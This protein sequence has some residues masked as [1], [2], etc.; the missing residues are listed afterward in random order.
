MALS[1]PG[2]IHRT[3]A[4]LD[5]SAAGSL[6]QIATGKDSPILVII[7]LA[8]GNDGLNTIVPFADD[9]YH[10]ARPRLALGKNQVIPV[11]DH[12]GL[13]PALT[14]LHASLKNGDAAIVQGVGYPNPNRSHFRSME[15]WHTATDAD[16][17]SSSGWLGRYFDNCCEGEDPAPG[18]S[19]GSRAP[20]AFSSS[21]PRGI[22]L[23][24]PNAL[25]TEGGG[26]DM[27]MSAMDSEM[28]GDT[29]SMLDG[30]IEPEGDPADFIRRVALDAQIASDEILKA[31][32]K[33]HSSTEYPGS[34]LGRDL[35]FIAQMIAGGL[36]TRVYYAG[37][38]GFDTHANQLQTHERLLG[39][40]DG[41]LGAFLD[42]LRAQGNLDRVTVL[43]FS[44][45]GR[46]VQENAGAGTDHGA[47]API[48]LAG[49]G[50]NPGLCGNAP[51]LNQ[52]VRGDLVH[53]VD[54]RTIYASLLENRLGVDS[55]PVLGGT[56]APH[57]VIRSA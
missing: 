31:T 28:D 45:F 48:F 35:R 18:V 40:F 47:A 27:Q 51:D 11:S 10:T 30:R 7:Q 39:Q 9:A 13:H 34:A 57:E 14:R 42:D 54:F 50:V 22:A 4:A 43:T 17:T 36:S 24:N 8:G 6:T 32:K 20:Q 19:V 1:L 16:K 23:R 3:F 49:A 25:R 33:Y 56:F 44:E 38:G 21:R 29:I 52:L 37:M 41:A 12:L 55:R 46:R 26:D 15:I 53:S 2:F 5:Q